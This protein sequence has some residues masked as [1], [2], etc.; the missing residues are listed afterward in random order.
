[1]RLRQ[2]A[3]AS[4]CGAEGKNVKCFEQIE[5]YSHDILFQIIL[6]SD[7]CCFSDKNIRQ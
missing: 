4:A 7:F 5:L 2:S 3:P 1:M 6:F